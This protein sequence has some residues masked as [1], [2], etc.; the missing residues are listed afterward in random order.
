LS[1][2]GRGVDDQRELVD[3]A[4]LPKRREVVAESLR[5]LER[6]EVP[7]YVPNATSERFWERIQSSK[8]ISS[9]PHDKGRFDRTASSW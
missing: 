4:L 7:A 9:T 8:E 1:A 2:P 6:I 3:A 5:V